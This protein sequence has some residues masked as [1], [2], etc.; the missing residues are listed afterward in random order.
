MNHLEIYDQTKLC[1]AHIRKRL[2][3]NCVHVVCE[4][5]KTIERSNQL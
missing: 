4:N 3:E 1:I 5:S 2:K